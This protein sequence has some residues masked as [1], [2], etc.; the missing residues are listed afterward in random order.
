MASK[1]EDAE[2]SSSQLPLPLGGL[3]RFVDLPAAPSRYARYRELSPGPTELA[4]FS[5]EG[6]APEDELADPP[7][8]NEAPRGA[9]PVPSPA[10]GEDAL[11]MAEIATRDAAR[12]AAATTATR[13]AP[14]SAPPARGASRPSSSRCEP[15]PDAARRDRATRAGAVA[16]VEPPASATAP[17]ANAII[18]NTSPRSGRVCRVPSVSACAAHECKFRCHAPRRG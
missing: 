14:A 18:L 2:T 5:C 10:E 9:E 6:D 12:D 17:L 15:R 11:P 16:V 4:A 13:G 7:R 1:E 8:L 3:G